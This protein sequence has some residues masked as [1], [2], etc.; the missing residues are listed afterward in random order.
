MFGLAFQ[1]EDFLHFSLQHPLL[2]PPAPHPFFS[3]P[4]FLEGDSKKI[5][6]PLKVAK[7]LDAV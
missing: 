4:H 5:K 2:L 1:D 6:I 3:Q 7:P